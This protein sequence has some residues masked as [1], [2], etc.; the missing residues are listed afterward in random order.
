M[1]EIARGVPETR[2]VPTTKASETLS[3]H[4]QLHTTKQFVKKMNTHKLNNVRN[5]PST[6]EYFINF[7]GVLCGLKMWYCICGSS[8][9]IR[10]SIKRCLFECDKN[11]K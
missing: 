5:S 11:K 6:M 1:V 4:I 8:E 2:A 3:P 9:T 10:L 7:N